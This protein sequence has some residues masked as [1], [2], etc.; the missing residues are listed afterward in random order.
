MELITR[1][2]LFPPKMKIEVKEKEI[3]EGIVK[4]SGH[5]MVAEAI[6]AAV[7]KFTNISVDTQTIRVSDPEKGVRYI[8]L[9]PPKVADYVLDFDEGIEPAPFNFQVS[10]GQVL[11]TR[12]G[13]GRKK[14]QPSV[15]MTP[16]ASKMRALVDSPNPSFVRNEVGGGNTRHLPVIVGGKES[17]PSRFSQRRE[18][19]MRG[20]VRESNRPK[21]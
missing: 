21:D 12:R 8:Y 17:K 5:C 18:Y 2:D 14:G 9:T 1:G 15:K 16:A 7:P 6:K 4:H 20:Y 13:Q 10:M 3:K 11:G 19:G